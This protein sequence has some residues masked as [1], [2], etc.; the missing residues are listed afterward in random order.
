MKSNE[1]ERLAESIRFRPS[2]AASERVIAGAEAALNKSTKTKSTLPYQN[3]WKIITQNRT[4]QVACAAGVVVIAVM[5]AANYLAGPVRGTS[6]A[7]G[8]VLDKFGYVQ[9]LHAEWMKNGR[10]AEVWAKRPNMLRIEYE[11]GLCEISNGPRMWGIDANS[12]KAT[13]KKSWYFQN[14]QQQGV[15]VLDAL[16]QLEYSQNFSGFFT[17]G[18]VKQIS[19]ENTLYDLYQMELEDHGCRFQFEALVD[20]Q[21]HL[22]N[23]TKIELHEADQILQVFELR[24]IDYDEPVSNN[25]FVFEPAEGMDV[26]IEKTEPSQQESQHGE[27]SSLRGRIFWASSDKPVCGARVSIFGHRKKQDQDGRLRTEFICRTETN[28]EGYWHIS[29]VPAPTVAISVRSWEL[30]W[31]SVPLFTTNVGLARHP[32]IIVDGQSDYNGLDFRVY[33]P[34]DLHARITVNVTDENGDPIEGLS[35]GLQHDDDFSMHQH[36]YALPRKQQFTG[37]DGRFDATDIWPTKRPVRI[38]VSPREDFGSTYATRRAQTEPF[39]IEPKQRY[40]FHIVLPFVRRMKVQVLDVQSRPLPGISVCAL[41][42]SGCPFFPPQ[43]GFEGQ[44]TKSDGLVEISGMEPNEHVIIAL[45][46]L[47]P[48]EPDWRKPLSSA[49]AH[50]TAPPDFDIPTHQIIFDERPISIQGSTD[51]AAQIESGTIRLMVAGQPGELSMP[52]LSTKFDAAGKFALNG[53]P[54]GRVHLACIYTTAWN[55]SRTVEQTMTTE[56]GSAYT[57]KITEHAMDIVDQ[58]PHR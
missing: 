56:P 53:V 10:R 25:M 55:D 17:E 52:F 35:A 26:T 6:L 2:E 22:I 50:L 14:A 11:A 30:D 21:T 57:V 41:D 36:I 27:G 8:Q 49:C 23:S 46:R 37:P 44:L 31:P 43:S 1:I 16:V 29:G 58:S 38:Y 3:I 5:L 12:N 7:F 28:R 42:E 4:M 32:R 45:R 34:K 15:D 48:R 24:I 20:S 39:V 54:P 13:E 18:P 19:I 40:N 33:K 47:D 9:T 51:S